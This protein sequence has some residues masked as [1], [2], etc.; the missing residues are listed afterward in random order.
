MRFASLPLPSHIDFLS[1]DT[2]G[3]DYEIV[4]S[5]PESIRPSLIMCEVDKRLVR[6]RLD[7]EMERRGYEFLWG[8][9]LNSAYAPRA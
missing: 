7:A 9:Y 5:I 1:I 2:E 6:E 3:Y 8:T 4:R